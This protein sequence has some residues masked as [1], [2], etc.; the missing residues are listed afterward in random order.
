MYMICFSQTFN[1]K[2]NCV[3][4]V[5][6]CHTKSYSRIE[7]ILQEA[8]ISF[9]GNWDILIM[10]NILIIQNQ[11][12]RNQHDLLSGKRWKLDVALHFKINLTIKMI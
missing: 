8:P 12:N 5:Y 2:N 4:T 3:C 11:L 7:E 9:Q 10:L 1:F 6:E